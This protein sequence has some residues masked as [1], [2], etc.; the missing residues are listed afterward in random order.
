VNA[1]PETLAQFVKIELIFAGTPWEA[2]LQADLVR[3]TVTDRLDA[4][5]CCL[6]RF[7]NAEFRYHDY[8]SFKVGTPVEVRLGWGDK[9]E[10]V[11]FGEVVGT[12]MLFPRAGPPQVEVRAFDRLFRLMRKKHE[13]TFVDMSD[14]DVASQIASEHGL[15]FEGDSTSVKHP[16]LMQG[17]ESDWDFLLNRARCVGRVV[18]VEDKKLTFKKAS[19]RPEPVRTLNYEVDMPMFRIETSIDELPSSVEVR[20]WDPVSKKQITGKADAGS[21][22]GELNTTELG[23]SISKKVLGEAPVIVSD[24][25]AG[26]TGEA[27]KLAR[28]LLREAI[29]DFVK[30]DLTL[31]GDP[32]LRAGTVVALEGLGDRLA[33][34]YAIKTSHH[35][36][37][38]KGYTTRCELLRNGWLPPPPKP[39]EESTAEE[40]TIDIEATVVDSLGTPMPNTEYVVTLA[41]GTV[42]KGTTDGDGI[43]R[44]AGC[45]K[46]PYK[47]EIEDSYLSVLERK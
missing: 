40:E 26:S 47:I 17:G 43:L 3:I 4:T 24:R 46:G 13:R 29:E 19:T 35:H 41:D 28:S 1:M 5:D 11:F 27:E 10:P 22:K 33:G 16:Y 37:D 21:V 2:D 25:P 34:G 8:E 12:E 9:A 20:T 30:A 6:M 15:S 39:P 42:R 32:L 44:E 31:N 38:D 36:C 23:A 14:S 18:R 45:P 7:E